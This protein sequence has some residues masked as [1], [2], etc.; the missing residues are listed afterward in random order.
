[1][2]PATQIARRQIAFVAC[3]HAAY[4][5]YLFVH[6]EGELLHWV[7]L[8]LLPLA[9]LAWIGPDRSPRALLRSIGL[10]PARATRGLGWMLALGAA[11]QVLQLLNVRQRTE[12]LTLLQR[13]LGFLLPI[14]GLVLL[15]GTV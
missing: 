15:V 5:A 12:L 8:V 14:G 9:A 11:F 1:M 4:V 3:Y 13:P 7:T 10:D 6:P 2:A